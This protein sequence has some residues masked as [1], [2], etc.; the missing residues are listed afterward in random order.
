MRLLA[1]MAELGSAIQG[2]TNVLARREEGMDGRDTLGH[3]YLQPLYA[4][5]TWAD[6]C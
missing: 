4:I 3:D 2:P 6:I 5:R 1:V